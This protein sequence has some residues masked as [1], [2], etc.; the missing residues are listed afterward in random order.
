MDALCQNICPS[1]NGSL[2]R[3]LS[4]HWDEYIIRWTQDKEVFVFNKR[5]CQVWYK[6]LFK[7]WSMIKY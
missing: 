5:Q 1:I 3:D 6:N 2:K 7:K 4:T